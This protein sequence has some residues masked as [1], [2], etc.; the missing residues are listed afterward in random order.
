MNNNHD[1]E[2]QQ[3]F[4]LA[5]LITQLGWFIFKIMIWVVIFLALVDWLGKK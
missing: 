2:E 5:D 3:E 4:F 1:D